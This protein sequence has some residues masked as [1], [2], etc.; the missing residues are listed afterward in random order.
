M[1]LFLIQHG[2]A[3]PKEIDPE[4]GLSEEGINAVNK[5]AQALSQLGVTFDLIIASTKKRSI[6]TARIIA[7]KVGYSN[8]DILQTDSL[9]AKA[10]KE[11]T[12][13]ILSEHKDKNSILLVG[14]LPS[15]VELVSYLI[16]DSKVNIQYEM[17]GCCMI[18][19]EKLEKASG[20]LKWF[21]SPSIIERILSI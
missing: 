15:L 20:S 4:H 11:Q 17:G 6:E 8:D 1:Q 3:I 5:T 7:E 2:P 12:I 18:D 10:T 13:S 16:S 9:K 14:H 19:F 21:L